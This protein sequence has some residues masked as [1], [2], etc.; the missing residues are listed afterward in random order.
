MILFSWLVL[1]LSSVLAAAPPL[2]FDPSLQHCGVLEQRGNER[3]RRILTRAN[4]T[5]VTIA[6]L[7]EL[8][9]HDLNAMAIDLRP[10]VEEASGAV[11]KTMPGVRLGTKEA[12]QDALRQDASVFIHRLYDAPEHVLQS[13]IESSVN[14]Y[15]GVLGKY[16]LQRRDV[17]LAPE[18]MNS[19]IQRGGFEGPAIMDAAC[20]VLAHELTHALQDQM[21]DLGEQ[22]SVFRDQ[23]H[24]DAARGMHEGHATFVEWRVAQLLGLED[25]FWKLNEVAQGWGKDGLM[26]PA[27]FETYA[28]YGQGMSFIQALYEKRGIQST[29][30]PLR[31]PPETTAILFRPELYGTGHTV[32]LKY[33]G[34]LGGVEQKAN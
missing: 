14:M 17:L 16:D 31:V 7:N 6:H 3:E 5:R 21:V 1:T 18:V 15:F 27:A 30:D 28:L 23:D 24:F 33:A 2:Q 34:I 10:V 11:F 29:W 12:V 9:V 32:D 26:D 22:L 13:M 20:L 8:S 4:K 25:T 19:V